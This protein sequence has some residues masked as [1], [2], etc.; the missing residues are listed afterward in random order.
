MLTDK[1]YKVVNIAGGVR[2]YDRGCSLGGA[3][4]CWSL[5]QIYLKGQLVPKNAKAAVALLT[6][7]CVGG[8]AD[9]CNDLA[10]VL[11]QGLD[12]FPADPQS[13]LRAAR[14]ACDIDRD[15]C[16][17]SVDQAVKIGDAGAAFAFATRGCDAN[18]ETACAKLAG[19]YEAGKGTS[20]DL[21]KAAAARK[22]ACKDGD[23]DE[24]SCK[25]LGIPMKD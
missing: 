3:M 2:A 16:E 15:Y 4:S 25:K 12:D 17:M 23:G 20:V 19:M 24:A 6:K 9:E 22:R 8:S 14:R 18:E 7:A 21:V 11:L 1:S 5:A 13:A 10:D